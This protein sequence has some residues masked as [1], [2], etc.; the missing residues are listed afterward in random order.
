LPNTAER[1]S[2]DQWQRRAVDACRVSVVVTL[3]LSSWW[4]MLVEAG[5][6]RHDAGR[7]PLWV[8]LGNFVTFTT[9]PVAS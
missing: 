2:P 5:A 4:S 3:A 6:V 8:Q 7:G 9:L 1:L